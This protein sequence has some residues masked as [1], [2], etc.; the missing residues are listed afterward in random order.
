[1]VPTVGPGAEEDLAP[2]VDLEEATGEATEETIADPS[3]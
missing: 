2:T 3:K 1:M